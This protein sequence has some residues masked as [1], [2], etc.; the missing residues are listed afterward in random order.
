[1]QATYRHQRTNYCKC[2]KA[3]R[4]LRITQSNY[5][6]QFYIFFSYI[7]MKYNPIILS[8]CDNFAH[9]AKMDQ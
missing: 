9:V 3:N 5:F 2:G 7:D 8:S 1:M 4:G 6:T